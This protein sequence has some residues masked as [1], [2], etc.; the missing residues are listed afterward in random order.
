[1]SKKRR[2][3]IPRPVIMLCF[4][5]LGY[6]LAW[7]ISIGSTNTALKEAHKKILEENLVIPKDRKFT[8]ETT[9][10]NMRF[11]GDSE[12]WIDQKVLQYNTWAPRELDFL[13]YLA[14]KLEKPISFLDIGANIGVHSMCMSP[15]V[16]S[17]IAV[18][19]FPP[20]LSVFKKHIAENHL[21]NIEILEVGFSNKE[22]SLPFIPPPA[23]NMGRGTF[24][25]DF[26]GK[27]DTTERVL[28]PLVR[29]DILLA[30]RKIQLIKID[31][32]GYERFA[33]EGIHDT[34]YSS[35]PVVSME[36]NINNDGGFASYDQLVATFPEKYDFLEIGDKEG[37]TKP[38]EL[39]PLQFEAERKVQATVVAIPQELLKLTE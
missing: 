2:L 4:A 16:A 25:T 13:Y 37:K 30:G 22:G 12:S 6:V 39:L 1:M 29:G 21:S 17:V 20:V 35:R 26:A 14:D 38:F 8:F 24:S 23:V 9:L 19:P 32:E 34:L 5:I 27:N 3:K 33:L 7:L 10:C 36:L 11:F 31:I 15:R 28:L 18:E